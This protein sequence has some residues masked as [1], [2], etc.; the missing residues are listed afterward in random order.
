MNTTSWK[1]N[2]FSSLLTVVLLGCCAILA[3]SSCSKKAS[4]AIIGKWQVQGDT[5]RIEFRK[6]G[7]VLNSHDITAGPPGNTRT[8]TQETVMGKYTFTDDN[9]MNLQMKAGNTN[10]P[11][12]S[13]ICIVHVHGDQMDMTMTVPQQ[14]KV[15]FKRLE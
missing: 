6:D 15:N 14:H 4:V 12:I 8:F 10:N 9:H 1:R 13:I 2:R 3:F 7:T 11:P 5:D